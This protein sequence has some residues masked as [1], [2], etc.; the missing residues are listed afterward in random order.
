MSELQ[1]RSD[2]SITA[3]RARS[4]QAAEAAPS[5]RPMPQHF[6]IDLHTPLRGQ[7]IFIRRTDENGYVHL[8]GQHFAVSQDWLHRLV[9]CEVDFDH[10]CI[11]CFALRRR[12][13]TEQPLLNT[14]AYH[15]PDK[16]FY[17]EP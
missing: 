17:G 8:L 15:R 2:A 3:H 13:P 10:H 1:A 16:P 14:L 9:R 6:E 11:R 5:R 7:M 4:C 12:A